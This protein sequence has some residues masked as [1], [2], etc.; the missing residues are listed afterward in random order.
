MN[1]RDKQSVL[2]TCRRAQR[3]VEAALD[4]LKKAKRW[5]IFDAISGGLVPS[6]V[7]RS[8]MGNVEAQVDRIRRTLS[9]LRSRISKGELQ[10]LRPVFR[11]H[12]LRPLL[13]QHHHRLS[14][15]RRDG[16]DPV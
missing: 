10:W 4:T 7:K 16:P 2:G 8:R 15:P 6:L 14:C 12:G 1:S 9:E 13:R 3:E 5:G 11:A